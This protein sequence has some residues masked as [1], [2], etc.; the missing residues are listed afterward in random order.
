[1]HRILFVSHFDHARMGGQ[2]SMLDLIK[3]LD[4][5]RFTPLLLCQERGELSAKAEALG[6]KVLTMP[7]LDS[8]KPKH[9]RHIATTIRTALRILEEEHITIV[10]PDHERDTFLFGIA[11]QIA[12]IPLIWHV[13][14]S[15]REKFDR[16]NTALASSVICVSEGVAKERFGQNFS[17]SPQGRIKHDIISEA[18]SKYRAIY[19]GV[20]CEYFKP[21][22]NKYGQR[23]LLGIPEN[24]KIL[25][26]AGQIKEGKGV[27]ELIEALRIMKT[28]TPELLPLTL[29]LGTALEHEVEVRLQTAIAEAGLSE[30]IWQLGQRED[31]WQWMQAMDVLILP[32]H[33]GV[34]GMGRVLAEAQ[35]CGVATIGS[36]IT[37]VREVVPHGVGL[38]VR[39]QSPESIAEALHTVFSQPMELVRL[40]NAGRAFALAHFDSK[41][42]A[43]NVE[44]VYHNVLD[45]HL[46]PDSGSSF[47]PQYFSSMRH[48]TSNAI[49][50]PFKRAA[51][52]IVHLALA[53]F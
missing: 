7:L 4:R 32:S 26:F 29:M 25:G 45:S 51:F 5:T 11:A 43:R 44:Q 48:T 9:L 33:E 40:Q 1:M 15:E 28:I 46:Q 10:H 31:I 34:E 42:H 50:Q 6:C 21:V 52:K 37:G 23:R 36:D 12:R 13:R 2:K 30:D 39:P 49:A 3:H 27:F 41:H 47:A 14:L 24:R 35:A 22:A 53:I 16:I 18:H 38:R 20:D 8:I 19:N 17:Q